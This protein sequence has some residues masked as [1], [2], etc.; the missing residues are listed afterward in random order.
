MCRRRLW[1][2]APLSIGAALGQI[3]GGVC[4]PGTLTVE[5]GLW[6]WSISLYGRS[7]RGTW[8]GGAPLLGTL[9]IMLKKLWRQTSL[10]IGASLEKLEVHLPG[11]SRDG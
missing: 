3:G 4:S 8:R 2:W 9:K 6:K 10:S 7:V 5:G 1:R 11:T